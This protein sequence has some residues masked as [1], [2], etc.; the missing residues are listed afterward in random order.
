MVGGISLATSFVSRISASWRSWS[1]RASSCR[2]SDDA[3]L[4]RWPIAGRVGDLHGLA[5][6]RELRVASAQTDERTETA[7]QDLAARGPREESG[8]VEGA[9]GETRGRLV[10]PVALQVRD[11]GGEPLQRPLGVRRA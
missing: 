11:R 4:A 10:A 5:R 8:R 2:P 9:L 1:P 7:Q 3:T 6:S